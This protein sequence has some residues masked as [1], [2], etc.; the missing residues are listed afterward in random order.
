MYYGRINKTHFKNHTRRDSGI[1]FCG[2]LIIGRILYFFYCCHFLQL[3]SKLILSYFTASWGGMAAVGG[4]SLS[5][6]FPR[7][8]MRQ[9]KTTPKLVSPSLQIQYATQVALQRCLI[10]HII[11][12]NNTPHL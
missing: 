1:P 9:K 10:F 6:S 2:W 7:K 3:P 4:Y 12:M 5:L 8:A 11:I